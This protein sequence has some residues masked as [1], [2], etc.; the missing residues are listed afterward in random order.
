MKVSSKKNNNM[1]TTGTAKR[2]VITEKKGTR[3]RVE[4]LNESG[5]VLDIIK[6]EAKGI[7]DGHYVVLEC[8]EH[9]SNVWKNKRGLRA[10]IGEISSSDRLFLF[11]N[12]FK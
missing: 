7:K 10:V 8:G 12:D 1:N 2:F 5:S 11:Q 9:L 6:V 4:I 3:F